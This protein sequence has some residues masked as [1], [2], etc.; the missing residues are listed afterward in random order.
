MELIISQ[1]EARVSSLVNTF[2]PTV[3]TNQIN[4]EEQEKKTEEA[5]ARDCDTIEF[6]LVQCRRAHYLSH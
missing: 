3:N 4:A 6:T 1:G 2:A 5:M